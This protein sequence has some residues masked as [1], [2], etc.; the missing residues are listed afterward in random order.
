MRIRTL[1]IIA[2]I[3]AVLSVGI[4]FILLGD[5][6]R[7]SAS[8]LFWTVLTVITILIGFLHLREWGGKR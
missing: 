4:P 7:F 2:V 8:Y 3:M 6:P 5:I 1:G